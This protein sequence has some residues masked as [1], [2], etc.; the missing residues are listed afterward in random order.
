VHDGTFMYFL[1]NGSISL[2]VFAIV[3]TA[4]LM[5]QGK[6]AEIYLVAFANVIDKDDTYGVA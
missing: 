3:T 4:M 1:K 2:L 5:A 6:D